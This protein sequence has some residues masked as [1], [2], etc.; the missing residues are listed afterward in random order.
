MLGQ[1]ICVCIIVCCAIYMCSVDIGFLCKQRFNSDYKSFRN[2]PCLFSS[3]FYPT[4]IYPE[5]TTFYE[6][7]HHRNFWSNCFWSYRNCVGTDRCRGMGISS[8]KYDVS[9]YLHSHAV[10]FHRMEATASMFNE[11]Y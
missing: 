4:G 5:K 7:L 2:T 9:N 10:F 1:C 8:S 11:Q 3:E 6:K